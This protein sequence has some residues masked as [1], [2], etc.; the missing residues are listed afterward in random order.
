MKEK[1]DIYESIQDSRVFK[2]EEDYPEVGAYLYVYE[3]GQ[4]IH[5][6]LQ[7][8]VEMCKAFAFEEFNVSIDGWNLCPICLDGD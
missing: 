2:I 8:N 6:Y 3:N 1:F 4:C 7:D 5:D